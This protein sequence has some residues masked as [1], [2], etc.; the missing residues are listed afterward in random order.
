MKKRSVTQIVEY[1]A[2]IMIG[3]AKIRNKEIKNVPDLLC[4]GGG[5]II[6]PF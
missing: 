2:A 3:V 6:D 1:W 5:E 4:W